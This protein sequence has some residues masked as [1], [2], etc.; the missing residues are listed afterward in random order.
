MTAT[1]GV[2]WCVCVCLCV[3]VCVHARVSNS[4]PSVWMSLCVSVWICGSEIENHCFFVFFYAT[5]FW[6]FFCIY[7][8]SCLRG[9][10]CVRERE[11][12]KRKNCAAV[13]VKGSG[14]R[15]SRACSD[16]SHRICHIWGEG[17]R[18][19]W[20]PDPAAGWCCFAVATQQPPSPGLRE[21]QLA[22]P[23]QPC[24]QPLEPGSRLLLIPYILNSCLHHGETRY[25]IVWVHRN[26]QTRT[27]AIKIS[28]HFKLIAQRVQCGLA[29]IL[30]RHPLKCCRLRT[31]GG[32]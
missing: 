1:G 25:C 17:T 19:L 5:V 24:W 9:C 16:M 29:K 11:G 15:C 8:C 6:G 4:V 28:D 31:A 23:L 14:G 13:W 3:C 21:L 18:S 30:N 7:L 22:D 20:C 2:Q 10:L 26:K 27:S 32:Y 12:E